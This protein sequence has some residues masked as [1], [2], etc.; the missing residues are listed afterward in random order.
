VTK[1]NF[2]Q[3]DNEFNNKVQFIQQDFKQNKDK[4]I[5]FLIDNIMNVTIEL[6]ENIKKGATD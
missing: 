5:D 4:V 1:N 3:L 2:E 6:P